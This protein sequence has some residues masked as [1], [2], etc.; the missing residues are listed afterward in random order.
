MSLSEFRRQWMETKPTYDRLEVVVCAELKTLVRKLGISA[1]INSRV[2]DMASFLKK[3]VLKKY[4]DP[5]VQM[6]DKLGCRIT[7]LF[8]DQVEPLESAIT[9]MYRVKKRE[10]R[11][12]DQDQLFGYAAIHFDLEL[13]VGGSE[14][15]GLPFELQLHT[16]GQSLWAKM[17]HKLS[18]KGATKPT[19]SIARRLN[20]L[21]ALLELFDQEIM[22]TRKAI[23]K[24]PSHKAAAVLAVLENH[25]FRF[26]GRDFNPELSS[27]TLSTLLPLLADL[28]VDA[29]EPT[30]EAYVASNHSHL[31][32]IFSDYEADNRCSPF[33]FQPEA[34]AIFFLLDRDRFALQEAWV[35]Q[36]PFE[37]LA[38]MGN[39]W[40]T[41]L[42]EIS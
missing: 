4:S 18:Y 42:E 3:C 24:E 31:E 6:P 11:G 29:V 1:E 26:T 8:I 2:K 21:S 38:E 36:Y 16:G 39:I 40:G 33:L 27:L 5:V 14:F 41:S 17:A 7:T 35:R 28:S 20:R 37:W 25:Y 12:L 13:P 10:S 9:K 34:L 30:I 19:V 23:L 22:D 32:G 15:D